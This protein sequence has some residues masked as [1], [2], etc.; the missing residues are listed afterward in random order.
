MK[1]HCEIGHRIAL[2]TTD[3]APIADFILKHHEWWDGQGYPLG[4]SG[5]EIPLECRILAVVDAYDTM[6]NE[7]PYKGTMSQQEAIRELWRHAGTQFEPELVELFTRIVQE[8]DDSEAEE[9]FRSVDY[10]ETGGET[11]EPEDKA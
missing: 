3:L 9:I 5:E 11:P 8:A 10:P 7:R 4:L 2:S 6:T 1:R